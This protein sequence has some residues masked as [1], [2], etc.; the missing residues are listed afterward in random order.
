MRGEH[1]DEQ[2]DGEWGWVTGYGFVHEERTAG[3]AE[4]GDGG[5]EYGPGAAG[6]TAV[7]EWGEGEAGVAGDE[8]DELE[9]GDVV[10]GHAANGEEDLK[11]DGDEPEVEAEGEVGDAD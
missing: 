4:R 3:E 5:E 9:Q 2:R 7:G 11:R 6:E 10:D 1:A 8:R